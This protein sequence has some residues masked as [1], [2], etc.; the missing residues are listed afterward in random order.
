MDVFEE[1]ISTPEKFEE[2]VSLLLAFANNSLAQINHKINTLRDLKNGALFIPL[3]GMAGQFFVP[4]N[5]YSIIASTAEQQTENVNLAIKL[6][7]EMDIEVGLLDKD[8]ILKGDVKHISRALF[9]IQQISISVN[10]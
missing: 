7:K 1:L 2:V 8:A 10:Q 6:M 4:F 9:A 5:Q 3:I